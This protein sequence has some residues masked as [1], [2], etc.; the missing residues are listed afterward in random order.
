M[1]QNKLEKLV[2][3]AMHRNERALTELLSYYQ[4]Y[5]F[6]TAYAFYQNEQEALD[7]VSECVTKV[8]LNIPKLKQPAYFKTWMTKILLNE[9]FGK[10]KKYK[11][12]L[13]L[14]ELKE[15]GYE[16]EYADVYISNEEKMDLYRAMEYLSPDAKKVLI[17]KYFQEW[18]VREIAQIL[19]ISESNV[20]V[21]LYRGRKQL[22]RIYM[23]EL[24]YEES[25]L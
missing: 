8:Y 2:K 10:V 1:D 9:V 3:K 22:R 14:D 12:Q 19:E 13:S 16:A 11:E 15:Q 18:S 5:L 6:R 21:M 4:E 7:A 17:L 23:E 20:K 24:G 25:E